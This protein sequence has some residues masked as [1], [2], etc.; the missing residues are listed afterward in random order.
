MLVE[1]ASYGSA[2]T[3]FHKS[4]CRWIDLLYDGENCPKRQ[5]IANGHLS[6]PFQIHQGTAQ[7]CPLSPLLFLVIVEGFTRLVQLDERIEGIKIGQMH[8]KIRHFADNTIETLRDKS[9]LPFFQE[10]INTFCSATNMLENAAKRDTLPLGVTANTKLEDRLT[11]HFINFTTGAALTPGWIEKNELLISLG[12]SIGN[13]SNMNSFLKDKYK[14]AKLTI[15]KAC[16]I[17][18]MSIIGRARILN[19]NFYGKL[20]YYM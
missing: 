20:R 16:G 7:G 10:H 9:E 13:A 6:K 12:I 5:T 1:L 8:S 2:K 17:A 19:A 3:S 14:G 11:S 4:Y 15:S 18:S